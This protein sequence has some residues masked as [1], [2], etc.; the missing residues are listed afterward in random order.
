MCSIFSH[1]FPISGACQE[2]GEHANSPGSNYTLVSNDLLKTIL[3]GV[4]HVLLTYCDTVVSV[5]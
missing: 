1:S 4:R 5:C 2:E 3:W